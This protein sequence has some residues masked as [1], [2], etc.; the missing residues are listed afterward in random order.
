VPR[1]EDEIPEGLP[2]VGETLAGKYTVRR[3]IACGG[4]GAV[5]EVHHEILDQ[6]VALKVLLPEAA[7]HAGAASRFINEARA[8]ARIRNEH[9]AQVMDVGRLDDGSAYIVLELLRG[10]DLARLLEERGPLPLEDAVDYVLQACEAVA[11]AH[12]LGIIHRDLKPANLFLAQREKGP[13]L[14]KVLDFGI[15]KL[16]GFERK[17]HGDPVTDSRALLGSPSYMSPEQIRS[18]KHIDA[19][20]DLWSLGVIL[21]RLLAKEAPFEGDN[22]GTVLAS[23]LESAPVPL[24]KH[25]P[26][27]PPELESVIARCLDRNRDTRFQS[28][29]ELAEALAPFAPLRS[30]YSLER[31][32]TTLGAASRRASTPPAAS[33]D[34]TVTQPGARTPAPSATPT[35]AAS[36]GTP[37]LEPNA[38]KTADSWS[39]SRHVKRPRPWGTALP[40]VGLPVLAVLGVIAFKSF[41][42]RA[43]PP[44]SEPVRA[45][46]A[47]PPPAAVTDVAPL[48][49]VT[50]VAAPAAA[51]PSAAALTVVPVVAPEPTAKPVSAP[52]A[53]AARKATP[54]P[55]ALP[56]RAA[57]PKAPRS[58]PKSSVDD[59][60]LFNRK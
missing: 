3:L 21:Y 30:R 36:A 46:A 44:E 10:S 52:S 38:G 19:R 9:V 35:P 45:S 41:G 7:E 42:S 55:S 59:S 27:V 4:M 2:R 14:V 39:E 37:L 56:A 48:A 26:E 49:A 47:A 12:A 28:V 53:S 40:I 6:A 32:R 22:L 13:P 5:Y 17:L 1:P 8:S 60:I 31:I 20:S 34:H 24:R 43:A 15:S 33:G 23:I 57:A 54:A 51:A 16:V 58:K 29:D 25:R 11:E 18:S 50:N